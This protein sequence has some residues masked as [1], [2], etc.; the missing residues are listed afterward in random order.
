MSL[1]SES[2]QYHLTPHGWVEGSESLDFGT[3][4]RPI[5]ADRVLTVTQHYYLSSRWSKP[6]QWSSID[7]QHSDGALVASLKEKFGEL[8]RGSERYPLRG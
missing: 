5:P 6:D 7:W 8:P 4:E 2:W 1:S 3:K